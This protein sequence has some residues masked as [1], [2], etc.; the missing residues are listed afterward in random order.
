MC[1]PGPA[2][3]WVTHGPPSIND[4]QT[5]E[6]VEP[7]V[8]YHVQQLKKQT[9]SVKTKKDEEKK[10]KKK[11]KYKTKRLFGNSAENLEAEAN[12]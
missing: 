10:N 3:Y 12:S 2:H 9:P 5:G 6:Q 11:K 1:K 7:N 4:M 8:L